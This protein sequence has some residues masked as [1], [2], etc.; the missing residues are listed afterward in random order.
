MR[1]RWR[2][3][4]TVAAAWVCPV[5]GCVD[6]EGLVRLRPGIRGGLGSI[7]TRCSARRR[8]ASSSRR[9]FARA[10]RR[11]SSCRISDEDEVT[12]V[13]KPSLKT[14]FVPH[15]SRTRVRG[16]WP[17]YARVDAPLRL[18]PPSTE[19]RGRAGHVTCA[20]AAFASHHL[21]PITT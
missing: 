14:R 18:C 6:V 7:P 2:G 12:E 11:P 1:E 5:P 21:I 17:P 10:I 8:S 20:A 3:L 13:C 15:G 16:R 19:R 4:Y 9:C